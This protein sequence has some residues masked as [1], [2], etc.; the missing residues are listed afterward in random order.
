M[1][2]E[3]C[4]QFWYLSYTLAVS[5]SQVPEFETKY[6]SLP[7]R[8]C[9]VVQNIASDV[10]NMQIGIIPNQKLDDELL[11]V[12]Q[13]QELWQSSADQEINLPVTSIQLSRLKLVEHKNEAM[14]LLLCGC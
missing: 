11:Y 9:S 6:L 10:R 5:S 8:S 4:R 3:S 14:R 2:S 1:P 7:S 13:L 12:E